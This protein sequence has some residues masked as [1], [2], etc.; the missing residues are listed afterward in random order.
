MLLSLPIESQN[1]VVNGAK[2]LITKRAES[3]ANAKPVGKYGP[4]TTEQL[5]TEWGRV[6]LQQARNP[7]AGVYPRASA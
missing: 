4:L 3:L 1:K 2:C 6:L 5:G 7:A